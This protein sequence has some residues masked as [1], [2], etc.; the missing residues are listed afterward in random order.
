MAEDLSR[1]TATCV[2]CGA[3]YPSTGARFCPVCGSASVATPVLASFQVA[4]PITVMPQPRFDR[5]PGPIPYQVMP[6]ERPRGRRVRTPIAVALG[7]LGIVVCLVAGAVALRAIPLNSASSAVS[8]PSATQVLAKPSSSATAAVPF[9][10]ASSFDSTFAA[11]IK[12]QPLTAAGSG[13]VGVILYDQDPRTNPFVKFYVPYLTRAFQEAGYTS[14]FRIDF[15]SSETSEVDLAKADLTAGAKVLLVSP[16]DS[17]T[18]IAIQSLAQAADVPL[19][20]YDRTESIFRGPG[21]YYVTFDNTNIGKVIGD[22]FKQ[23]VKDWGVSSP[24]VFELDGGTDTDPNATWFANGY[25]NVLWGAPRNPLPAGTTNAEGYKLVGEQFAPS[26]DSGKGGDIFDAAF[27][28]HPEINATLEA[29][30][31]LGNSVIK[32]LKDKG[33]APK[34]IPVTGQD[35]TEEAMEYILQGYQCGTIYKSP[36]L[37]AQAAVA[38]ATYLRAGVTPPTALVNGNMTDP[39]DPTFS[40]PAVLVQNVVWVTSSNMASTVIKDGFI[41]ASDLCA[42]VGADVCAKAG[43]KS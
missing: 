29:N 13:L 42:A 8:S 4:A 41:S 34:T 20:A 28:A 22:G 25:N 24:K 37:V 1:R 40:E 39:A 35:A 14:E 15:A 33:V 38:L 27:T 32:H 2:S 12:L 10:T 21:T 7:A 19:I 17:S 9:L 43:I 11:M 18:G 23:C 30:D 5:Q 6:T 36:Y 3:T 16:T 26:W 31:A